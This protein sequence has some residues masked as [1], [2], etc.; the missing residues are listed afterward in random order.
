VK[1]LQ[2]AVDATQQLVAWEENQ[3]R[4]RIAAREYDLKVAKLDLQRLTK[5]DGPLQL[6]QFQEEME[7]AKAELDRFS[8]FAKELKKLEKQGFK[9]PAEVARARDNATTYREKYLAA[10]RRFTSYRDFVFPS[11]QEGAKAKVQNSKLVLEQ[12]KKAAVFKV[13]RAEAELQQTIAKLDTAESSLSLARDELE[14]S[15]LRAP[16]AG[17]AILYEAFRDGQKRK[18]RVGD[19][20]LMH[21]PILY[22][23][24]ISKFI[25]QTGVREVDLYK[26]QVGQQA[27]VR[28]DAYPS[29]VFTAGVESIGALA[30]ARQPGQGGGKYFKVQLALS[31]TD[32]RLRP[33]MTARVR[34]NGDHGKNV[35]VVPVQAVYRDTT[36]KAFCYKSSL[37]G[38]KKVEVSIGRDDDLRVEILSGLT[39]GDKVSLVPPVTE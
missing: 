16:F 33:G 15:V 35:L 1:G 3:A 18:P 39:E 23:P 27:M 10:K 7:K 5:G 25:V 19:T 14:K 22:L 29:L 31:G 21:Q 13:A 30:A 32:R 8:S 6:A 38:L 34:I 37:T 2:A 24:D 12:S 20:V 36:G 17:I 26:V 11:L 4:Q 28:F 9:N